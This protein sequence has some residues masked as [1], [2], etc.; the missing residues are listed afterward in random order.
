MTCEQVQ[1]ALIQCWGRDEELSSEART[2]IESCKDCHHE[3]L[4]LRNTGDLLHSMPF[5]HAPD[6]FTEQVMAQLAHDERAPGWRERLG[7]WLVPSRQPAW[8]RA[9]AL[10][11]ALAIGVAGGVHWY[12]QTQ[13]TAEQ[14]QIAA[15]GPEI[16]IAATG[17][18]AANSELD[19]LILKH[20]TLESS[21][22]FSDDVGVSLV[23][24]TSR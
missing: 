8:A 3:A 22:P 1:E 7:Q 20:Q 9:A 12:G 2:H 23:V 24:Y 10:G 18:A 4:L 6:G 21:Q 16:E 13:Q 17:D 19:D 5:E 15:S 14:A 11:A